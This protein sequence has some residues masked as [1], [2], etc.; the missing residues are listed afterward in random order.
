MATIIDSDNGESRDTWSDIVHGTD[1][2][3][4][5]YA[6]K[7]N[8]TLL[9]GGGFDTF[10]AGDRFAAIKVVQLAD[11]SVQVGAH[12]LR[13]V[14]EIRFNDVTLSIADALAA[15]AR[16][17]ASTDGADDM[18]GDQHSYA[19]HGAGGD[20][21]LTGLGGDDSLYGGKGQD[22]AVFRGDRSDYRIVYDYANQQYQV[23][24]LQADRDGT[25]HLQGIEKLEFAD[26][27]TL[28]LSL[29]P[30]FYSPLPDSALQQ[31]DGT[32]GAPAAPPPVWTPV[33][34]PSVIDWTG[35]ETWL[36]IGTITME[37]D[38][39]IGIYATAG[40]TASLATELIEAEVVGLPHSGSAFQLAEF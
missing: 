28:D 37:P 25:D 4:T 18:V 27:T 32:I 36:A 17:S 8:D 19:L 38:E 23:E 7:G 6:G 34:M 33:E 35:G 3:D 16:R 13:D 1:E 2:A 22:T 12:T 31:L 20:D 29:P 14:E 26:G 40:G 39:G 10:V 24:D 15:A 5:L 30:S 21:R 11:G 9:G